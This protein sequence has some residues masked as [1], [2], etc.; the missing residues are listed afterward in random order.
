[1]AKVCIIDVDL[2][3]SIDAIINKELEG[4]TG[5]ARKELDTA[6]TVAKAAREVKIEKEKKSKQEDEKLQA[7]MEK[8]YEALLATKEVGLAVSSV[9]ALVGEVVPNSS[10]F[11]LRMKALLARKGNPY[12]LDRQKIHGTAHYVLV[13]FNEQ[14]DGAERG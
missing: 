9:M 7:E 1:M 8:A 11:T 6:I 10:A 12:R 2:G 14:P 13:A 5:L 3:L 4:I